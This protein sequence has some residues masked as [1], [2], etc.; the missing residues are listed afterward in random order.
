M[1]R[2]DPLSDS[3]FVK[4]ALARLAAT[5]VVVA[6]P[7]AGVPLASAQ[8]RAPTVSESITEGMQVSDPLAFQAT[9]AAW[10]TF[11][12]R[13]SQLALERSAAEAERELAK[14][15]IDE[16]AEVVPRLSL[17]AEAD[18]LPTAPVAG[19][20]GRQFG[21]IGRLEAAPDTEFDRL[22]LDM[23]LAAH[24]EAIGLFD[25][26]VQNGSGNL[27]AF[28]AEVLP[29]LETRRAELDTLLKTPTP[30]AS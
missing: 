9:A 2:P 19:L 27:R 13:A 15:L 20:D 3:R 5:A 28:A 22:Y 8:D 24:D 26:Y 7:F 4:R 23:L 12:V 25:G 6:M 14:R 16:H 29:V 17:A 1:T 30:S 21:M 18:G 11:M 10:N